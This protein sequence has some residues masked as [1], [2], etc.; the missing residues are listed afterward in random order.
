MARVGGEVDAF[1]TR[2]ELTLAHT[3]IA[4]VGG[5]P[6]KVECNTCHAVHRFRGDGAPSR[7]PPRSASRERAVASFEE[8][9]RTKRLAAAR[10]DSPGETFAVDDVV[11]HPTFGLGWVSSVRGGK[12]EVTFRADVKTLVH[13]KGPR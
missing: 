5:R 12:M 2:C 4:M 11:E 7:V 10:R 9:L 1:C 8:V 6:V 13:G 3:V